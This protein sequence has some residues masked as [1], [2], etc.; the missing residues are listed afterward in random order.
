[1]KNDNRKDRVPNQ[2]EDAQQDE[3]PISQK[4]LDANRSNSQKSTGPRTHRGKL[5]VRQNAVKHGLFVRGLI[6]TDT[7]GQEREQD[8]KAFLDSFRAH[9]RPV[10]ELEEELVFDLMLDHI[11][12]RRIS[13]AEEGAI[14]INTES[15]EFRS[16]VS[17]VDDLKLLAAF[18]PHGRE[19]L[20]RTCAGLASVM[21]VLGK[22]EFEIST[23]G[24][25]SATT[26][27]SLV[28]CFGD[29][30]ALLDPLEDDEEKNNVSSSEGGREFT[31][32]S[33]HWLTWIAQKMADCDAAKKLLEPLER[34]EIDAML[35]AAA[36]PP[37]SVVKRLVRYERWICKRI[38]W[39]EKRLT[40]AQARRQ[41]AT[42]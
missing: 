38:E 14:R 40:D 7:D 3:K 32:K 10:G 39:R 1:M 29:Q 6:K 11:K 34:S 35:A 16:R 4:K 19:K 2:N 41:K 20:F 42:P 31:E 8:F 30:V 22:A 18:L 27:E 37:R 24:A 17:R 23:Y 28:M 15:L 36:V 12:L 26:R 25:P 21:S 5:A 13:R 9:Y 33:K